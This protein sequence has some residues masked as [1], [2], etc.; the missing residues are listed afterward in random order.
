MDN[1]G[2]NLRVRRWWESVVREKVLLHKIAPED[3]LQ[4]AELAEVL[5]LK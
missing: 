5:L 4:L 2:L 1:W 3:R